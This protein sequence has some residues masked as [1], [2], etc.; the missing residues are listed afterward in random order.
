MNKDYPVTFRW[1][2]LQSRRLFAI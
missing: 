2:W 1:F